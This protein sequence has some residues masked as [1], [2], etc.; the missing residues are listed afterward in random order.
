[1]SAIIADFA[2]GA[3][4]VEELH[5]FLRKG[6][7]LRPS[8]TGVGNGWCDD[9]IGTGTS[10]HEVITLT[11]TSSTAFSV[12]GSVSGAMGTGVVGT[13]VVHARLPAPSSR[14]RRPGLLAT[15]SLGP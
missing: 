10:V 14:A 12:V 11:F 13:L 4:L 7:T 6:H 3:E 15:R 5:A 1:M 8:F 2:S 9:A